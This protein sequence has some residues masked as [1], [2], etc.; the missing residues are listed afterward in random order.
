MAFPPGNATMPFH[1]NEG[2]AAMTRLLF[3]D[4]EFKAHWDSPMV[5]PMP[6]QQGS[7]TPI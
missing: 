1:P 4:T 2:K 7:A 3:G 6:G 5:R